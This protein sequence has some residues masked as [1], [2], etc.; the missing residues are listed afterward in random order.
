MNILSMVAASKLPCD[1]IVWQQ[2]SGWSA[3]RTQNMHSSVFVEMW[4]GL[5][6]AASLLPDTHAAEG[7]FSYDNQ[8]AW[9]GSCGT[10]TRQSPVFIATIDAVGSEV[11]QNLDLVGWN[12]PVSG[13]FTNTGSTVKFTPNVM[14][15]TLRNHQGLY[16]VEQFHF[17][18]GE[19]DTVGSEHRV[20]A[21]AYA[22]E[23]HF[24]AAKNTG[25]GMSGDSFSVVAVLLEANDSATETGIW[26]KLV[27]PTADDTSINVTDIV[28][29]DL[30]PNNL[31]YY[32]YP[33]S[34]TT[35]PCSEYVQWFV[36]KTVSKI[37]SSYLQRLRQIQDDFNDT[38]TRDYR[39]T[40]PLN[41]RSIMLFTSRS[42]AGAPSCGVMTVITVAILGLLFAQ[43]NN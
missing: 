15:A 41:T 37:P 38:L 25:S 11:L 29:S 21:I 8:S 18:W 36:L 27:P 40:Q 12:V 2:S 24:V 39:D 7:T 30:L 34:L 1:Y 35:P 23:V 31:D 17:H 28:F 14:D 10:G 22:A 4:L 6:F 42:T 32:H 26:A 43:F 20:D 16:T 33:G 19:N 3:L 9:G 5:L 13:T